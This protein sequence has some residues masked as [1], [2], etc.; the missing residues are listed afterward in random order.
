[1]A[2][3]P[4]VRAGRWGW[5]REA[6]EGTQ[7]DGAAVDGWLRLGAPERAVEGPGEGGGAWVPAE[8][9]GESVGLSATGL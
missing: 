1:M 7:E 8:G 4:G 3:P 2:F 5:S 9:G 6:G